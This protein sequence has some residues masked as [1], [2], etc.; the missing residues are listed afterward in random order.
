[1]KPKDEVEELFGRLEHQWDDA[2]PGSGHRQRFLNKLELDKTSQNKK[3]NTKVWKYISIAA[4]LALLVTIGVEIFQQQTQ[5]QPEVQVTNNNG[6]EKPMSVK[7]TE[8]YFSSLVNQEIEKIKEIS[9]P[10]TKR[11]VDDL[12][13][14][15]TKLENDYSALETDLSTKGDVKLI[16]NAMMINFQTRINLAQEVLQ[17]IKEIEQLKNTKHEEH[18]V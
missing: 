4:S 13:S 12:K 17:K 7:R 14:Q 1:M 3:S 9:T 10:Q 2:E 16:L 11:L 15:L 5:S 6:N 8:F 18:T